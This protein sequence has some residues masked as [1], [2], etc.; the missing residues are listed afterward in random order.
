MSLQVGIIGLPNVGK[1]TFFNALQNEALAESANFPFCTI[2]PNVGI[3]SV[4]DERLD[5]LT[6]IAHPQK[7]IAALIKFVDIAGLVEGASTGE[8]LGNKFLSHIR[9]CDA[10]IHIVRFFEDENIIH[11]T[12]KIQPKNDRDIIHTELILSD[13][14]TLENRLSKMKKLLSQNDKQTHIMYDFF[15]RLQKGMSEG[16]LASEVEMTDD[17]KTYISD[18]HLLTIKP[19][20]YVGNISDAE[21]SAIDSN[22]IGKT[23]DNTISTCLPL[24]VSLEQEMSQLKEEEKSEMMNAYNMKQ[25]GLDTVIQ[26][27]YKLLG[28]ITYFTVG[29]QEV[30][31]WTIKKGMNAAEAAGVIHSDFCTHFIRADVVSYEDFASCNGWKG[32]SEKGKVRS[33]GKEYIVQDGDVMLIKSGK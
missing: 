24:C 20:M 12:G 9:L 14:Q 30:R 16:K 18:L 22:H 13:L 33:E 3:V 11:V 2:E 25:S 17:E 8:G 29:E 4:P 28:L 6:T 32:S 15:E 19:M 26:N 31:A 23:F 7:T 1:S 21:I 27:A 5:V 10:L